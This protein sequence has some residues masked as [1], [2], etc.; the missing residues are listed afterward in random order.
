VFGTVETTTGPTVVSKSDF[1]RLCE[2]S[3]ARV[4]QWITDRKIFGPAIVSEGRAAQINV[5]VAIE[6]LRET[7]D[8]SHRERA[9]A[10]A[11]LDGISC[12]PPR[13]VLSK[14]SLERLASK[15]SA[16]ILEVLKHEFAIEEAADLDVRQEKPQ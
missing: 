8:V 16:A 6:Q 2:V 14:A 12:A 9:S 7:L 4:T 3:P 13:P 15:L 5:A 11:R 10:R 1:A